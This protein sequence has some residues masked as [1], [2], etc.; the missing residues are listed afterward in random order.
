[1][2]PPT[3]NV[4][5]GKVPVWYYAA[6]AGAIFVAYTFYSRIRSSGSSTPAASSTSTPVV[7]AGSYGQDYSGELAN[8]QMQLQS[9]QNPDNGTT[10]TLATRF[11]NAITP[12]A[13][14]QIL[15]GSGYQP[16]NNQPQKQYT[17]V[18]SNSHLYLAVTDLA[19]AALL[20]GDN[21]YYQPTPNVFAALPGGSVNNVAKGT[22]FFRQI[23]VSSSPVST[24]T[25]KPSAVTSTPTAQITSPTPAPVVKPTTPAPVVTPPKTTTPATV[26]TTTPTK[27]VAATKPTPVVTPAK[28]VTAVKNAVTPA[29]KT[30]A[31][32]VYEWSVPG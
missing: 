26:T 27:V 23:D 28:V 24:S 18:S 31:P 20:G 29:K 25:T 15:V 1:M 4:N 12:S 13:A 16:N 17:P 32:I 10:T 11:L 30:P 8:I 21:L 19:E 7:A 14:N 3:I 9:L 6:G 5:A 2:A 22:P